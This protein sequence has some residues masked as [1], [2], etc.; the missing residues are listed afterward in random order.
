V[1][2]SSSFRLLRITTQKKAVTDWTSYPIELWFGAKAESWYF[3]VRIIVHDDLSDC[4]DGHLVLIGSCGVHVVQRVGVFWR[5]VGACEIDG[6]NHVELSSSSQIV[7]KAGLL[8]NF[9][10][11][12]NQ[13]SWFLDFRIIEDKS[14]VIACLSCLND[15]LSD[16]LVLSVFFPIPHFQ[17][18]SIKLYLKLCL[19]GLINLLSCS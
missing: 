2:D 5:S 17:P 18:K 16:E 7:N 19:F 1:L 10:S 15:D 14:G 8:E 3:F 11:F 13:S 6:D 12:K 4:R 9:V